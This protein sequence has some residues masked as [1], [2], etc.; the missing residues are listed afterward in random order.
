L[1]RALHDP[2]YRVDSDR[3]AV[4]LAHGF[5]EITMSGRVWNRDDAIAARADMSS[6]Y[7]VINGSM[8]GDQIAPG[9]VV[10]RYTT[11]HDGGPGTVHIA[12][13]G[14]GARRVGGSA[15]STRPRS[16]QDLSAR[17]PRSQV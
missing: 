6:T 8:T 12:L 13:D 16:H 5:V 17:L 15:G 2:A 1:E 4:L 10:V 14:G 9:L 7:S 3:V 11:R